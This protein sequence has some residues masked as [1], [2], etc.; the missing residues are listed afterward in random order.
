MLRKRNARCTGNAPNSIQSGSLL[1]DF[2]ICRPV[3]LG[4]GYW[5]PSQDRFQLYQLFHPFVKWRQSL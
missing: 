3:Y 2:M 1:C 4:D 5:V